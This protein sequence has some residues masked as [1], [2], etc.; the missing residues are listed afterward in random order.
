MEQNEAIQV[1]IN[2]ATLAQSKGILSFEDAIIVHKA[3]Q[4]FI[5]KKEENQTLEVETAEIETIIPEE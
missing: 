1:L 3:I 2:V 4:V 5:P